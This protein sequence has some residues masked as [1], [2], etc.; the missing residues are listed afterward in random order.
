[1]LP[2]RALA[3]SALS[4]LK[5]PLPTP[6]VTLRHSLLLRVLLGG[7]EPPLGV[8]KAVTERGGVELLGRMCLFDEDQSAVIG[9]LEV[10][11]R[12]GEAH[13]IRLAAIEPQLGG[14]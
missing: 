14:V 4:N 12:L 7:L 3:L 2:G 11:L 10:A 1:M 6:F 5:E 9:D 8:L 13:H